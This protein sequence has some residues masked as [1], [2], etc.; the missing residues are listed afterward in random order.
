MECPKD[1]AIMEAVTYHN[2]TVERCTRCKGIWFPGIEHKE[3]KAMKGSESI[4]I[5]SAELGKEYDELKDIQCP[6]CNLVMERVTDTFQPHIHYESCRRGHGAFFDAGEFRDF[7][8]ET[9]GDFVKSLTLRLK[10][11]K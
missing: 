8:E 3:L 1:G 6:V 5:G 9:L 7:K 11:K 4:D 2:V 10:K